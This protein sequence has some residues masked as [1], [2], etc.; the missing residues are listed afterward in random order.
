MIFDKV[1]ITRFTYPD[2]LEM[3][4]TLIEGVYEHAHKVGSSR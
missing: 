3:I 1:D 4:V 2:F